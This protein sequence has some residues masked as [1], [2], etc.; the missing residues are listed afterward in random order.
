MK[1]T[2]MQRYRIIKTICWIQHWASDLS[3][4]VCIACIFTQYECDGVRTMIGY[5]SVCAFVGEVKKRVECISH[6]QK[7][8]FPFDWVLLATRSD[9]SSYIMYPV[10]IE[11]QKMLIE[12]L[13]LGLLCLFWEKKSLLECIC[14]IGE[15]DRERESCDIAQQRERRRCIA[16]SRCTDNMLSTLKTTPYIVSIFQLMRFPTCVLFHL[17]TLT[18]KHT[19][20]RRRTPSGWWFCTSNEHTHSIRRLQLGSWIICAMTATREDK[21]VS[22]FV[23]DPKA[24]AKRIRLAARRFHKF[25]GIWLDGLACF[26][27]ICVHSRWMHFFETL[28]PVDQR[29]LCEWTWVS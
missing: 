10:Q 13:L 26:F 9:P 18:H 29:W 24:R 7:G 3:D 27:Y 20:T 1:R 6:L 21:T 2:E 28:Y 12:K 11:F 8:Q 22:C 14:R 4:T 5:F 16:V 25:T 23:L 17:R 15:R 19:C